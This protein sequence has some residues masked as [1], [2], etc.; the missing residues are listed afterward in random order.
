[1]ELPY[2]MYHPRTELDTRPGMFQG[3][4]TPVLRGAKGP[5][6]TW[7]DAR[8][9][10]EARALQA[11]ADR[12]AEKELLESL[13][14]KAL[15][16]AASASKLSASKSQG[17]FSSSFGRVSTGT[18]S[19]MCPTCGHSWL[20]KHGKNECPKCLK[21]LWGPNSPDFKRAG[22]AS[23]SSLSSSNR[24]AELLRLSD[25]RRSMTPRSPPASGASPGKANE[26]DETTKA[27]RSWVQSID[28][29][30]VIARAI[31]RTL[32]GPPSTGDATPDP[33]DPGPRTRAL[34]AVR[35]LSSEKLETA[36]RAAQLEGLMGE[37]WKG[38]E[39]L[40]GM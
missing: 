26:L 36:L 38:I 12:K 5:N 2:H 34:E 9:N 27:V 6:R 14:R 32:P 30:T 11:I 13:Q 21:P 39:E 8:S 10:T 19:K 24:V 16:R 18:V 4:T 15:K 29:S 23:S 22:S 7:S 33:S 20:D 1:M 37:L 17:S 40:N 35:G 28:V 31:V 25:S 3:P